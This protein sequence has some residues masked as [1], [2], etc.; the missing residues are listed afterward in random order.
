MT[1][2]PLIGPTGEQDLHVMSF[3]VR[4]AMD[5]PAVRPA[6]RWSIRAPAVAAMLASER[7][8]IVGLQEAL[9][10]SA[11]VVRAAL[12]PSYRAIGRGRGKNGQGEGCPLVF[13]ESRVAVS[14]WGQLALSDRPLEAGSR[15]WGALVPRVFVWAEFRL[16]STGAALLVLNTHLD[17][18]S[19][20][21]RRRSA[22]A[23]GA[24]IR[25]RAMP[26]V[27]VGDLNADEGSRTVTELT[28]IGGLRDSWHGARRRATAAWGTDP[29][30]RTPRNRGRRIDWILVTPDVEVET[31][32]INAR[33]Y[34]GHRPSDHLPVQALLRIREE[35]A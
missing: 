22:T 33:T 27:V 3:N 8:T 21:A 1:R 12:G 32:A 15:G 17:P 5:G 26:S 2:P 11:H 25:R 24:F 6:D 9:P 29:G 14:A 35:T 16:R 4:R 13:D 30:Y 23:I 18:L 28:R 7:P 34:A 10:R 31:T 19:G 20:R